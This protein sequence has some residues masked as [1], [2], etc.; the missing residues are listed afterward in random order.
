V[1][2]PQLAEI[3]ALIK[4]KIQKRGGFSQ[5]YSCSPFGKVVNESTQECLIGNPAFFGFA[6]Y[7]EQVFLIH[8]N[9]NG[10]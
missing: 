7:F 6:F 4:G 9:R 3:A 5:I 8:P 10:F 1:D 2:E